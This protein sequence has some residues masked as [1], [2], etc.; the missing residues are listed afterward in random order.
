LSN[1][2]INDSKSIMNVFLQAGDSVLTRLYNHVKVDNGH[3][4]EQID[5]NSGVQTSAKDLTWS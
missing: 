3:L 5:K 1:Y 2:K 4:S